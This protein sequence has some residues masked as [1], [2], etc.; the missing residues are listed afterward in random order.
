M[1]EKALFCLGGQGGSLMEEVMFEVRPEA[2]KD[3][4]E[5]KS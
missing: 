1:R 5:E 3:V 2:C 4:G